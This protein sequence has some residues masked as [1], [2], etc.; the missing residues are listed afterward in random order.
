[1]YEI[2]SYNY[3]IL[4]DWS[5]STLFVSEI[6]FRD[7]HSENIRDY[8]LNNSLIS[9][10]AFFSSINGFIFSINYF[11]IIILLLLFIYLLLN[12]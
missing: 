10:L 9:V 4:T 6:E 2:R 8:S 5:G 11:I 12:Y 7:L 3:W 1:M